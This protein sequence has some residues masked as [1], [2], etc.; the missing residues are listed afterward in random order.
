M[1]KVSIIIPFYNCAYVD[2]AIQSALNQTYENIEIILVND[3]STIHNEKVKPFLNK[4]RYIEKGNGGTASAL[5]AGIEAATGNYFSWLS[6]DDL[7]EPEK[8]EK[9]LNFMKQHHASVSYLSYILI[10][11]KNRSIS[12]PVGI[13]FPNR[14]LFYRHLKSGCPINGCTVMLK[15][16]IFQEVGLF[17]ESLPF[18]QDYDLWLRVVQKYDF[19]YLDQPLVSYRVH[20]EMGTKRN[21]VAIRKE[22]KLVKTRHR[23]AINQ[24]IINEVK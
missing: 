24:L 23:R 21:A 2:Q 6:S 4:I 1:D 9:Q 15:M 12:G 11:E 19:Y 14:E 20:D 16:K 10:D 13:A 3:G 22:I 18:T 8:I 17:D 5:N 7:Y